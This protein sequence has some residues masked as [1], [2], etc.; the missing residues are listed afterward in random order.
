[1]S[2]YRRK[3]A[4]VE[5]VQ[6]DRPGK[7]NISQGVLV[8]VTAGDW[9]VTSNDK[10]WIV[11]GDAFVELYERVEEDDFDAVSDQVL[12]DRVAAWKAMGEK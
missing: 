7:Y 1:M 5:A 9:L 11:E 12:S 3:P 8:P 10:S 4:V 2:K 6:L